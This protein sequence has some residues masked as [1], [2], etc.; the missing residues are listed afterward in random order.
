MHSALGPGLTSGIVSECAFKNEVRNYL[1]QWDAAK[2]SSK[3]RAKG[4]A[5]AKVKAKA[6]ATAKP[7]VVRHALAD[8]L[9]TLFGYVESGLGLGSTSVQVKCPDTVTKLSFTK[10]PPE[11]SLSKW[12]KTA[13]ARDRLLISCLA[14]NLRK[15]SEGGLGNCTFDMETQLED[16][17]YMNSTVE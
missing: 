8:T 2:S 5:K 3:K 4:K 10:K 11:V 14:D 7:S 1:V 15:S 16:L 13:P 17:D 6:K 9:D 12:T